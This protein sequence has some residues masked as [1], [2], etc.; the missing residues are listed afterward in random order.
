LNREQFQIFF[1]ALLALRVF[2]PEVDTRKE[3]KLLVE[4]F[5]SFLDYYLLVSIAFPSTNPQS[6]KMFISQAKGAAILR[7]MHC[8]SS[9]I[10]MSGK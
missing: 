9:T 1:H 7:L 2:V 4:D 6:I 10:Y 5:F 3:V 8:F